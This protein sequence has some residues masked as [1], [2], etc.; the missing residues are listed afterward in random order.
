MQAYRRHLTTEQTD[1]SAA[2]SEPTDTQQQ[3]SSNEWTGQEPMRRRRRP[4]R[5][6]KRRPQQ[7][8]R[9][10]NEDT[11]TVGSGEQK[12]NW[13]GHNVEDEPEV[14]TL[15]QNLFRPNK[16][17]RNQVETRTEQEPPSIA[18]QS[19]DVRN[20]DDHATS[21]PNRLAYRRPY[22]SAKKDDES[23]Q[24]SVG[25]GG[26][27]S[28]AELKNLLK[29]NGGLSLSEILQQQNLSLDDLLKGKHTALKALQNTTA[30]PVTDAAGDDNE[31]PRLRIP[32]PDGQEKPSRRIS[33]SADDTKPLRRLP[34]NF[35]KPTKS[36]IEII[37]AAPSKLEPHQQ[38]AEI[39]VAATFASSFAAVP[40][41]ET[42]KTRR[43][44]S[45]TGGVS[46]NGGV[47]SISGIRP[48]LH[49][50]GTRKRLL[51]LKNNI[52]VTTTTASTT[53]TTTTTDT[54]KGGASV[55]R[56]R[57]PPRWGNGFRL[58]ATPGTL[59]NVTGTVDQIEVDREATVLI[60]DA[61]TSTIVTPT[62]ETVS[63]TT[64]TTTSA[65]V[66]GKDLA[67]GRL[68]L[69]PRLLAK[70]STT[71]TTT[72]TS[73]TTEQ[74]P[75]TEATNVETTMLPLYEDVDSFDN[76]RDIIDKSEPEFNS[77][78]QLP[79]LQDL[80]FKMEDD[81]EVR[82]IEQL[83]PNIFDAD[84]VE[85]ETEQPTIKLNPPSNG[86]P[87]SL[88]LS[89]RIE[90]VAPVRQ[91]IDVT[92]RNPSL[93]TDITLQP[94]DRTDILELIE[95]RR[96]GA[97]LF[98]VLAQRNMT[99]GEL[100]EH[101]QRGSSQLHLAE[102]FHSKSKSAD[103]T[104]ADADE[105]S[106]D[107]LPAFNN[108]PSFQSGHVKSVKPDDI[109]TDSEGSSY[110]TSIINIK[111][112]DEVYKES[113]RLK[114]AAVV[115]KPS[116]TQRSTDFWSY[117]PL[118]NNDVSDGSSTYKSIVS[119]SR[120]SPPLDP[121][122]IYHGIEQIENEV[123][124]ANDILDLELSGH[125]YKRNSVTVETAPN[126]PVGVRSAIIASSSI[127]GISFLVFIIIFAACRWRQKRKKTYAYSEN[128]QA[129]RSRLPILTTAA[130][131]AAAARDSLGA[132][133]MRTKSKAGS[134]GQGH[135]SEGSTARM[136]GRHLSS[137][138]SCSSKINTMDPN[139]PEVQEYLYDAMRKPFQ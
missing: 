139:S 62:V 40:T 85:S 44:P 64:T 63:S 47:K 18:S 25:V 135:S 48:D 101:R 117:D 104:A 56:D 127:V 17:D 105:E 42:N 16:I 21:Q 92:E 81:D 102:I 61:N 59:V 50:S 67:K 26:M 70:L 38:G 2:G 87:R 99:L 19:P 60:E 136:T 121:D 96:S 76:I 108:F 14:S 94:D 55:V 39:Q 98:K 52:T 100:I 83:F 33:F 20:N 125:T 30:T 15:R 5:K 89:D 66:I 111:P 72:T 58:K 34:I 129:V 53:T 65:P 11:T 9:N 97:R 28:A 106:P 54:P 128:F 86:S 122:L 22:S 115:P 41:G 93:F 95:D 107:I 37:T 36:V 78:E 109:K 137:S 32:R 112:T 7:Q 82:T 27:P 23:R 123:A 80:A 120:M 73:A 57:L 49:N 133:S 110:F 103:A 71:T 35:P 6:R 51:P 43:L 1:V 29:K 138:N 24:P 118:D 13:S 46:V 134:G 124:R 77:I 69:R 31:K 68:S 10:N 116:Q 130:A 90:A 126:M 74:P 3:Q 88:V 4:G 75:E 119:S 131:Q 79:V 8:N 84:D 113:R 91:K 132:A 12:P 114:P 45:A